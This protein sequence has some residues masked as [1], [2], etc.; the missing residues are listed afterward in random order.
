MHLI[1]NNSVLWQGEM[2]AL[3]VK[4]D[5]I[6]VN[7]EDYKISQLPFR[8]IVYEDEVPYVQVPLYTRREG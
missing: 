6:Q 2:G 7:G 8:W 5:D 1:Y 3:P 4:G